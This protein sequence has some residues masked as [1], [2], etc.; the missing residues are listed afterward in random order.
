MGKSPSAPLLLILAMLVF[1]V[2][3]PALSQSSKNGQA[4]APPAQNSSASAKA[5]TQKP[6]KF[7]VK[8]DPKK[9]KE[10]YKQGLRAEHD[11]DWK[12]AYE[13]YSDAARWA[14]DDQEFFQHL[15]IAKGHVVQER[16]DLAEREAVSGR[17]SEA[18]RLLV[19]AHALDPSNRVLQARYAELSALFQ[20]QLKPAPAD[21]EL[22]GPVHLEYA[23][24]NRNFNIR[25]DTQSAYNEIA[26]QFGVE[27]A[28][29]VDLRSRIVRFNINDLDFPTALRLLGE[30]TG[31]FWRPL[32][33]HLFLVAEDTNQ[34]RKDYALSVVRTVVLPASETNEQMTEIFRLVREIAGITR[35][36]LDTRTGTITMRASPQAIAVATGLL[37]DLEKPVGELVLEIEVLEVDRNYSRQLG[38][39]PPQTTKIFTLSRQQVQE[40]LASQQGLIDVITQVFGTPSSLAGLT[41]TQIASLLGS[42]QVGIGSLIPPLVAFGGGSTTFLATMPGAT[43]NFSEMLS[44][45]R[46]GRRILLRAED[47]KPATFFVGERFPVALAQFSPSLAGTATGVAGL[48]SGNL[49][50]TALPTGASPVFVTTADTRNISVEDIIVANNADNSLTVFLGNGDGTFVTPTTTVPTGVGPVW[51]TSANFNPTVNS[52]LNLDLAVVNHTDNSVSILLGN[53]DGTF[54]PKTDIPTGTGTGPV[55]AVAATLTSSGFADLIVVN[56]TNDTLEVFL[57]KGDG[58]FTVPSVAASTIIPTGRAPSSIAAADLNGD[59]H[60][61]IVVTN[62]NDNTVSVFLG[63]GD[64][65]FKKRTDLTVGTAPV[66]VSTGDFSG[67][68]FLD[69]AVANNSDNTVSILNGVGDGTFQAQVVF[70]AGN[71]PTSLAVADFN[72]DGR[73]DILVAD[74]TDN[75]VSVLLN[76][77]SG[78]FGPNFELP[79]GTNPVAVASADFDANGSPDAVTADKGSNT[80]TVILNDTTFSG[81]TNPLAATAFPGV[82]YLDIGTKVKA[83]ARIHPDDEVSLHLNLEISSIAAQSF[84]GIP[85][86]SNESIEQTIRLRENETTMVM[87]IRQPQVSTALNGSPGISSIPGLGY[88]SG[89]HSKTDQ[90][91]DL[92]V[93]ITPR[94]VEL[95]PHKDHLIYAGRGT[96]EGQTGGFGARGIDRRG[97]TP[98]TPVNETPRPQQQPRPFQRPLPQPQPEPEPS[99]ENE[100]PPQPPPQP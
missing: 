95:A 4:G 43:A 55:A 58:T 19:S 9:A 17:L 83:T 24:G 32:T 75:A 66:W 33:K 45:V 2:A 74:Q 89:V 84:N 26:R 78:L 21:Q 40:A 54:Q 65:T 57:G 18:L 14:P 52:D 47:G 51:I 96:P 23:P 22:A 88:L 46:T 20:G 85:V 49:P 37:E 79:V 90:D 82:E 44:L 91:S 3:I 77:G 71:G 29:D 6:A 70:P 13:S 80:A 60:I 36:D 8:P 73:L 64:G 1:S 25:G 93:L 16:L 27:V 56:N 53:G 15:E 38:I 68:G 92:I 94:M 42:G 69:L 35:A 59:G 81:A 41:S 67:D 34:K 76:L 30:Q 11:G 86:I 31:T 7:A 5:S 10:A 97:E 63:N 98:P 12:A 48:I 62:Q 72:V 28:F 61:D 100:A 39:T 50:T 87:G 99:P